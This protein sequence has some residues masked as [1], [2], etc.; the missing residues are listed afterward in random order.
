M[1]A[2]AASSSLA[3]GCFF[4]DA[5]VSLVSPPLPPPKRRD[6]LRPVDL[7]MP[8]TEQAAALDRPDLQAFQFSQKRAVES[9]QSGLQDHQ[10]LQNAEQGR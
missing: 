7:L 10:L 2:A 4:L 3:S 5:L 1:G 9:K 8:G 6:R